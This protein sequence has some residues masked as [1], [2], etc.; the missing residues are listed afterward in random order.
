M[1]MLIFVANNLIKLEFLLLA[2]LGKYI[3]F[4]IKRVPGNL[5]PS[6]R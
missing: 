5:I 3:N 4:E 2:Y 1:I 6:N